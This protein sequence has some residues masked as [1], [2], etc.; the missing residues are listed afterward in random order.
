MI[1]RF[2]TEETGQDVMEYALLAAFIGLVGI[3]AWNNISAELTAH[4]GGWGTSVNNL[5]GCTPDPIA[6]PGGGLVAPVV[7]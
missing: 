1:R 4:Y 5:S 6:T 7:L 3:V 2:F